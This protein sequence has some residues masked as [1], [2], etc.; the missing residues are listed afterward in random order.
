MRSI[1]CKLKTKTRTKQYT[2]SASPVIT[3]SSTKAQR[4]TRTHAHTRAR[5][6]TS[7][8]AMFHVIEGEKVPPNGVPVVFPKPWDS[9]DTSKAA[10][11]MLNYGLDS[12]QVVGVDEERECLIVC[13][14]TKIQPGQL[15]SDG[16]P[17]AVGWAGFQRVVIHQV[18]VCDI[19]G[20]DLVRSSAH[21]LHK[22]ACALG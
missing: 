13:E 19:R 1:A 18:L 11:S 4:H 17:F 10:S 21:G 14:L 15:T 7:E 6:R 12:R 8:D 2:A 20:Q 22:L 5:A 16:Q 3:T 9:E